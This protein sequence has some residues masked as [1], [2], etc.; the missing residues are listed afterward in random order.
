MP[1]VAKLSPY[2]VW[3]A[4]IVWLPF[5]G[6]DAV[7]LAR[8]AAGPLVIVGLALVVLFACAYAWATLRNVRDLFYLANTDYQRKSLGNWPIAVLL[9]SLSV[10]LAVLGK[11]DGRDLMSG[12]IFTGAYV[13]GA[14]SWRRAAA[15]NLVLI[16]L[17][18]ALRAVFHTADPLMPLFLIPVVSFM[19]ML[20]RWS[21]TAGK[22]LREAQEEISRLAVSAERLRIARDLHDLLG[23]ALSLIALKSELARRLVHVSPER[24][25]KEMGDVE[26][27]ARSMLQEVREALSQYRRPELARE[28][29]SVRDI[30][31]AAGIAFAS[32]VDE[33]ALIGLPPA[34]EEALAWTLREG[35]TNLVRHGGA[36]SC[37]LR[38]RRGEGSVSVELIDDGRPREAPEGAERGPS[39]GAGLAGLKERAEG[40]GGELRAGF[41]EGGGFRLSVSLPLAGAE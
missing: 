2:L 6:L 13:G 36:R 37:T 9:S 19:V 21:L 35:V 40:L 38:V 10:V 7:G 28:L 17:F 12:F 34:Q 26:T 41:M 20:V 14:F 31:E 11:S 18:L 25:D 8:G 23:H 29:G 30:L 22:D 24:A 1:R 3:L 5:L 27:S 33:E 15:A 16:G 4:W 39:Q 32:E